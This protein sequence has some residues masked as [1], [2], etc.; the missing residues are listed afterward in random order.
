MRSVKAFAIARRINTIRSGKTAAKPA[1]F[2]VI[3]I[4]A[5]TADDKATYDEG[6]RT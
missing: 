5:V 4:S 1:C 3:R 2:A 6:Y